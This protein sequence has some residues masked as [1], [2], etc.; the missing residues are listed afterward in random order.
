MVTLTRDPA[1][2]YYVAFC[3]QVQIEPLPATGRIVGVDLGL[4]HLAT[5]STGEKVEAPK[6]YR[7]RLRYLRQQKR[8]L[9][10]K[11]KGSKR[12]EKQ[13]LRVARAEAHVAAQ[14][15]NGL[16]ALTTRL[17]RENDIICIEDL[18]VQAMARG[19]LAR[20]I[21]DAAYGEFRRQLEYKASW[22][23]RIVVV[24]DRFFPSSKRC[25][26]CGHVL[27]ELRLDVREW[28]CP[29]CGKVHD[30]DIN[31]AVNLLVEGI[32]QLAGSDSR[33]LRADAGGAC[34]GA[35]PVQ[36]PAD[37]A[38]NGQIRL[39]CQEHVKRI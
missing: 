10:R 11:T 8:A 37:E 29:K 23:G 9:A 17:V 39:A 2:R 35:V 26:D 24:V 7:A 33:D 4:T 21:H 36:V 1:G 6:H 14:R 32:R 22:Y 31:A 12:H 34:L 30:R 18:F 28:T 13:R 16:H 5:L 15:Q 20:S 38:R 27:D 3:T 25:S 19:L